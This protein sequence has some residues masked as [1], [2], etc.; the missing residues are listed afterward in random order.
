VRDNVPRYVLCKNLTRGW[1]RESGGVCLNAQTVG[2]I[3]EAA[4]LDRAKPA[5]KS[6]HSTK[7]PA[8]AWHPPAGGKLLI[9]AAQAPQQE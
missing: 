2:L 9:I 7:S 6:Q 8:G 5:K 4:C 3:A 1:S